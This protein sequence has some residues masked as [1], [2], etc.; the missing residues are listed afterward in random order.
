[1]KKI[2]TFII[3]CFPSFSFSALPPSTASKFELM[4]PTDI[5]AIT[6]VDEDGKSRSLEEFEGKTVILHFWATWC[7]PCRDEMPRLDDLK[8]VLKREAIEIVPLSIDYKGMDTVIQFY[9]QNNLVN[10]KPYLDVKHKMFDELKVAS[11][12]VTFVINSDGKL[13]SRAQGYV[14]WADHIVQDLIQSF[15]DEI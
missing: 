7:V 10:L 8:K 13:V 5:P 11:V 12:P 14:D 9:N 3:L 2:L 15:I 1:M 4:Q 6:F